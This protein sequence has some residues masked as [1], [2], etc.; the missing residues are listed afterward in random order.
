MA[1]LFYKDGY[2]G[3]VAKE[4]IVRIPIRPEKTIE[5]EFLQLD[6]RGYLTIRSGYAYDFASGPTIDWPPVVKAAALIHDAGCQLQDEGH[7]D[8]H[9]R[10]QFDKLFQCILKANTNKWLW[11]RWRYWYRGVRFDAKQVQTM[12]EVHEI[13]FVVPGSLPCDL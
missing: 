8:D 13:D 10:K 5:S 1:K 7:I 9:Q 2:K 3:Q 12:K 4:L 6:T 11:W